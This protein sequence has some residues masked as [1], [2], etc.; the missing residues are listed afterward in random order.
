MRSGKKLEPVCK[1]KEEVG[2]GALPGVHR[3]PGRVDV[4]WRQ[5]GRRRAGI[6]SSLDHPTHIGEHNLNER[7]PETLHHGVSITEKIRREQ[8]CLPEHPSNAGFA[9]LSLVPP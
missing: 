3:L 5:L 9:P 7:L 1:L 6:G 2:V 4:G 8:Q